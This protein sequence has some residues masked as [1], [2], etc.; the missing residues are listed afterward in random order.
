MNETFALIL[1]FILRIGIP[2]AVT[3]VVV[4]LLKR[5]DDR[6]QTEAEEGAKARVMPANPGCWEI[7]HCPSKLRAQCKAYAHPETSCW[8]VFRTK[9]GLLQEKCLGCKVFEQAP[10]YS[11]D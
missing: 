4:F 9:Q 5:L 7:N 6:W 1:G 2:V 11:G 8:Q 3:F 10:A